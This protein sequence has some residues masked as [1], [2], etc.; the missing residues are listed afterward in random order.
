MAL[1]DTAGQEDFARL[2]T[3]SYPDTHCTVIL[4]SVVLISIADDRGIFRSVA[5]LLG[6][7]AQLAGECRK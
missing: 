7:L 5:L 4:S 1:W 3:L 2:R 6:R